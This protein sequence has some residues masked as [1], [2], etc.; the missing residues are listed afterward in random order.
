MAKFALGD[1]A[2][3][4]DMR[5]RIVAVDHLSE[6]GFSWV[7]LTLKMENGSL[8]YVDESDLDESVAAREEA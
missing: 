4:L 5:G 8:L 6:D 7:Q 3:F 1:D 2:T